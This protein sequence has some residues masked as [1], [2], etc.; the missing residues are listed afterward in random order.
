MPKTEDTRSVKDE[1][2]DWLKQYWFLFTALAAVGVAWGQQHEK[3]TRL[4]Q[5]PVEIKEQN[6]KIQKLQETSAVQ[7]TE[8]KNMSSQ[9]QDQNKMLRA[10]IEVMPKAQAAYDR[11]Q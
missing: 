10:L 2:L 7:A 4:E 5:A 1:V 9:L 3:I 11:Q 6:E 8:I